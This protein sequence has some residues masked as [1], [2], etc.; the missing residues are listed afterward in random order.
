MKGG[1]AVAFFLRGD[2][3]GGRGRG[4]RG[5]SAARLC[6]P[7]LACRCV[8]RALN[9]ACPLLLD[10]ENRRHVAILECLK[11]LVA[12]EDALHA[13]RGLNK[14]P[15]AEGISF[16]ESIYKY[17]ALCDWLLR[18]FSSEMMLFNVT[19]KSHYLCHIADTCFEFHPGMGW[20]FGGESFLKHVK[21]GVQTHANGTRSDLIGN[22]VVQAWCRSM[23]CRFSP[24]AAVIHV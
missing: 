8:L 22:K 2:G 11:T 16:K 14:M 23:H 12:A 9:S 10:K 7:L 20:C 1:G 17:L 24:Q 13:T 21:K 5:N 3:G 19:I 4:A 15:F 18:Q 6:R